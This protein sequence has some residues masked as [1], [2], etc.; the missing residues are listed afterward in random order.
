MSSSFPVFESST[1]VAINT[2]GIAINRFK[3]INNRIMI[4]ERKKTRDPS[5]VFSPIVILPYFLPINAARASEM[6]IIN[7]DAIAIFVSKKYIRMH[8]DSNIYHAPVSLFASKSLVI[9]EK[10][11]L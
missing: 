4:D 5:K 11:I 10:K 6:L 1:Y 8:D 7:R 3:L 9:E 2:D